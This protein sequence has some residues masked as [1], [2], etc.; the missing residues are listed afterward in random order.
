MDIERRDSLIEEAAS[1]AARL[2]RARIA[3]RS[4]KA[5]HFYPEELSRGNWRIWLI[6]CEGVY[7]WA[8]RRDCQRE[9][10]TFLRYFTAHTPAL[11]EVFS[12]AY[13]R[14]LN[15]DLT[16]KR[17]KPAPE[18]AGCRVPLAPPV[19]FRCQTLAAR[20][21]IRVL[22][23]KVVDHKLVRARPAQPSNSPTFP[24]STRLPDHALDRC[25]PTSSTG[26]ASG[27]RRLSQGAGFRRG[28]A[29]LAAAAA[30]R[31]PASALATGS[32]SVNAV[33]T[34]TVLSTRILPWCA[35]MISRHIDRPTPVP[36][37]PLASGPCLV[38]K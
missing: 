1:V 24:S 10:R 30:L 20:C 15:A 22:D 3:W 2:H 5:K 18:R 28:N 34:P 16:P 37:L 6:D 8:S 9:W 21:L 32:L 26:K 25:R 31:R 38:V 12:S 17:L 35:S 33:P 29:E 7:R 19:F 4:M 23:R 11:R 36:P 27:T 14:G 13:G